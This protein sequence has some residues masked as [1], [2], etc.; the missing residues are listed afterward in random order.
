MPA[1]LVLDQGTTSSR[2]LVFDEHLEVLGSAQLP[3]AQ[4]FPSPG[5]VEHDPHEIWR[6]TRDVATAAL[7]AARLTSPDIAGVG[8]TNQRE[9]TVLWSRVTGQALHRAIVWQDRRT[10]NACAALRAGGAEALVKR[11][12]GLVLDP[13]FSAS[14]LQ[15]LLDNVP[16]ARRRAERGELAF[17]TVDSWL[18]W[19]LSGGQQHVTDASNASRTQLYDLGR[20][21]W[22][23]ELLALWNIPP[24]VLPEII[25]SSGDLADID[26]T[27]GLGRKVRGIAG[28]QQAALFGQRCFEPGAA[29]C[30]YGTG[31]FILANAGRT[32]P[33]ARGGLLATVAWQLAGERTY[34]LEGSVFMGGATVQWLRDGLGLINEASDIEALAA[35]VPDSGGVVLV[36]AFTG[37]GAPHWDA[38]ARGLLIGLSRGTHR[39]HIARAALE[40]IALQVSDVLTTMSLDLGTPLRELRVDGGAARNDLLLQLQAN[41]A[42]LRLRRAAQLETTAL[43]AALLAGLGAGVWSSTDALDQQKLEAGCFEPA[44]DPAAMSRLR[45][46][47]QAAVQRTLGWAALDD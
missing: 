5:W 14:K 30:T 15:W 9:T 18:L 13:Y 34:A 10:A 20:G 1:L 26:P 42:G 28:D 8:V 19:Q 35:T 40:A 12:S 38:H 3:L 27:L 33:E 39:G 2:A 4:H 41:L 36:P 25:D 31:C 47:W 7:R 17:G 21:G 37:L 46:R 24:S 45:R 29:K 43:G 16:D 6:A 22:D 11:R 23:P 44:G 32:V